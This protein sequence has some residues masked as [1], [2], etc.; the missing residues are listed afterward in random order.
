MLNYA[1]VA[2]IF[3]FAPKAKAEIEDR[4]LL[5]ELEAISMNESSGG[6]NLNHKKIKNGKFKGTQAGGAYGIIPATA[7]EMIKK[8]KSLN[9]KYS[10]ILYW[11]S[12]KITEELNRNHNLSKEIALVFWKKLRIKM[13]FGPSRAAY[14]WLYGP[15][16]AVNIEEEAVLQ[17]GYVKKFTDWLYWKSKDDKAKSKKS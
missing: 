8:N 17:N 15:G 7:Q 11:H 2:I 12:D 1:L 4:L 16:A 6:K 13:N 9:K 3:Y 14:A 10:H 5:Q